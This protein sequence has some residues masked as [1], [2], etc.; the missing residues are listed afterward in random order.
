MK[1]GKRRKKVG[2]DAAEGKGKLTG[3]KKEKERKDG[4][5]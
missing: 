3:R 2:V 5:G 1:N 4:E